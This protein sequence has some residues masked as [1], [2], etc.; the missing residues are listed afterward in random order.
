MSDGRAVRTRIIV[1]SMTDAAERRSRFEDRAQNAPVAWSFYPARASLHPALRY[2]EQSAIIAKGRPLRAGEI[3]CYSSHYAA[4]QDLQSDDADQY[5]VLEDDVIVDWTFIG[6]LAE[7]DLAA[8]GINYLRLYYKAA[9]R[10]ALVRENFIERARSIVELAGSAFGTQGYVISKKGAAVFLDHCRV[11]T[12]PID[13]E[14]D[15][16]WA[17]GIPNLAVFPFPIIEESA[18]SSIGNVRFESFD[19]PGHLKLR[20]LATHRIERWRRDVAAAFRRL[21]RFQARWQAKF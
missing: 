19:V 18:G 2:D 5:V 20:R 7:V 14:M 9:A 13:D 8:L 15:R 4:W 10:P 6:K 16:S 21:R 1:I 12:R 17:H 11:V 3:G